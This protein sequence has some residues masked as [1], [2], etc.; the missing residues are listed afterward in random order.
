M[1]NA[2]LLL[3]LALLLACS[4]SSNGPENNPEFTAAYFPVSDGDTWFYTNSESEKIERRIDGDTIINGFT[5]IR[6]IENG[7]TAEAW[8]LIEDGDSAGFYV[9]MLSFVFGSDT[10]KPYFEPPLRIPLNMQVG[11][12]YNYNSDL[13]YEFGGQ[14]YS[15]STKGKL[16]FEGFIDK[17]VPA[18]GFADVARIHY[19]DYVP[20]DTIQYLEYYAPDV[21]LLDNELYILDSAFINGEW[22]R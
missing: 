2:L 20:D 13:F 15:D 10:I 16:V 14:M 18:G 22:I 17:T 7:S 3:A 9:H 6:V 21:G 5:C 19:Y 12:E 11:E 8:R 1:R 4:S